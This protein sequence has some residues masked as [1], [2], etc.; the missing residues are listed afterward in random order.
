MNLTHA[1]YD[2]GSVCVPGRK[3]SVNQDSIAILFKEGEAA[4]EAPLLVLADG[5]GG[6]QGGEIASQA[7][8]HAFR[9]GYSQGFN[10]ADGMVFLKTCVE[11]AHQRVKERSREDEKLG[12]MGSTVVAVLLEGDQ[13]R[14]VNVG[15]SRAYLVRNQTL[16]QISQDQSLVADLVRAGSLTEAEA[17][18]HKR[19][20]VLS[21]A[22]NAKRAVVTPILNEAEVTAEDIILLCSD[23]LWGVVAPS[24]IW[25]AANELEPQLAA[26][27]LAEYANQHGGPDNISVLIARRKLREAARTISNEETQG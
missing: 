17:R 16:I 23:G 9:E 6:Y 1:E 24:L 3:R 22:I 7:V 27:K 5:M 12:G 10:R 2:F 14:V 18:T 26:E 4:S 11:R 20:N 15:D 21:M 25:A 8:V 19:K 13:V